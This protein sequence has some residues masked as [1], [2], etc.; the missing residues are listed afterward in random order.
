MVLGI[1][2]SRSVGAI[3]KTGVEL[4]SDCII[5]SIANRGDDA[6]GLK[7]VYYV[8][9]KIDWLPEDNQR[10][11][12]PRRL[13]TVIGLSLKMLK[14]K[15]DA[16]FIP[17]H[18]I[19]FFPPKKT[20][21]IIHDIA[22]V[23]NPKLYGFFERVFMRWDLWRSIRLCEKIFVSTESVKNDLLK[24]TNI[25]SGKIIVTGFGYNRK[26][27][28]KRKQEDRNKQILFIGR[29]ERKKNIDNLIEGFR[30]F[31]ETHKDYTLVLAGK[32]GKGFHCL[33]SLI[34]DVDNVDYRGYVSDEEKYNLLSKSACLA[35][36]A[37]EEGFSFPVLEAFDFGI[38]VIASDIPVLREIAGDG[39]CEF[40]NCDDP[41]SIANGIERVVT[42]SEYAKSLV[43]NG[44]LRLDKYSWDS[45]SGDILRIISRM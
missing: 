4:V 13:W 31:S 45:V 37:K 26:N 2:A 8:P 29:I 17:V 25:K 11:F 28:K 41:V 44:A 22:F 23:K 20:F 14:D 27:T 15:P 12:G 35:H 36:V 6:I 39:A 9:K 19:P 16:L 42:N 33:K 32:P 30:L 5:R 24:Y 34:C 1:D 38:P 3:Q 7:L 21:R 10:V 43:D 18:T 40:V